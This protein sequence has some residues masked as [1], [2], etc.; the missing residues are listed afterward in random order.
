MPKRLRSFFIYVVGGG[1]VKI[2][3][4]G[5][6]FVI[7]DCGCWAPIEIFVDILLGILFSN[8]FIF[9]ISWSPHKSQII[10]F[11]YLTQF[12]KFLQGF[13]DRTMDK[14]IIFSKFWFK[15]SAYKKIGGRIRCRLLY[16]TLSFTFLRVWSIES[17]FV[18]K[19]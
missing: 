3:I 15:F 10:S 17:S 13:R 1:G 5:M 16:W 4:T 12:Q 18:R 11:H 7:C 14:K 6:N 2:S 8:P 9:L 19:N